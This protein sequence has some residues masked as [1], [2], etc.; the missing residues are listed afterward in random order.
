MSVKTIFMT[1]FTT[2]VVIVCGFLAI[3]IFNVNTT[4]MQLTSI[5]KTSAYQSCTLFTQE[6]YRVDTYTG[7]GA[8]AMQDIL[9]SDGN[10]YISGDFY[11]Y[12]NK[13][14]IYNSLYSVSNSEFMSA[15]ATLKPYYKNLEILL[16]GIESNG[17]LPVPSIDWDSSDAQIQANMDASKANTYYNNMYTPVNIG[18]PYV[19]EEVINR[20]FKWNLAML[21]SNCN[22]DNIKSDE[23][24]VQ[25]VGYKGYR[26]YVQDAYVYNITYTVYDMSNPSNRTIVANKLFADTGLT[27][28]GITAN[29]PSEG[30][31]ISVNKDL[32][33]RDVKDNAVVTVV[34]L[35]YSVPV[36]YEGL[37][38]L[39]EMMSFVWNNEVDGLDGSGDISGTSAFDDTQRQ[40]VESAN[41]NTIPSTGRLLYTLVK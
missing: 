37:T 10:F 39:S 25:Y 40:N 24:G 31:T 23:N 8:V 28:K 35:Q 14:Q 17:S 21:Y 27:V 20:M 38:P 5:A 6:T 16:K 29:N 7:S 3:E 4:S 33:G 22:S 32:A 26:C 36:A 15:M 18:I 12:D 19:D 13:E 41:S 30:I 1:L 9:D 11:G 34:E 2:V